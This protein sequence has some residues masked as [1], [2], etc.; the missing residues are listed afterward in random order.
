M[1]NTNPDQWWQIRCDVSSLD[2]EVA[3]EL[4][5]TFINGLK[6]AGTAQDNDKELLVFIRATREQCNTLVSTLQS[7]FTFTA[8]I[9]EIEDEN[10]VANSQDSWESVNA[11]NLSIIPF[12][13]TSTGIPP[14]EGEIRIHPGTG[15]GTGHHATTR[16]LLLLLQDDAI[17]TIPPKSILD[18]GTGSAVLAIAAHRLFGQVVDA[19]DNDPMAIDNAIVNTQLNCCENSIKLQT[20]T[21]E[22]AACGYELV[23]ANLYA[24]LLIELATAITERTA[25]GG[26]ILLSGILQELWPTVEQ[27]FDSCG[28]SLQSK[29][30]SSPDP[31]ND[32]SGPIWVAAHFKKETA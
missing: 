23:I 9:E 1:N 2:P 30:V 24:E 14:A 5:L 18:L 17:K 11:L 16:M 12:L 25:T 27:A 10:W 19:I 4:G 8:N 15:F 29:K 22:D 6:D 20:G 28:C 7:D 3:A 32:D 13:E 31:D 21:I 26:T